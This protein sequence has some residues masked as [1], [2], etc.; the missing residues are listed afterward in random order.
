MI[1]GENNKIVDR[2]NAHGEVPI[3]TNEGL[4]IWNLEFGNPTVIVYI[5]H[6]L[7]LYFPVGWSNH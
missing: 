3:I 7:H 4:T 5:F 1:Y 2:R 6:A